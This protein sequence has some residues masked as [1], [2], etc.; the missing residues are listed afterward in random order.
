MQCTTIRCPYMSRA[1]AWSCRT[2]EL[3]DMVAAYR[4][5]Y[6]CCEA[7]VLR[8]MVRQRPFTIPQFGVTK[9]QE[10]IAGQAAGPAPRST[11][12]EFFSLP[13]PNR[14]NEPAC[15]RARFAVPAKRRC[16]QVSGSIPMSVSFVGGY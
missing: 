13:I 16:S 2:D 14:L 15:A 9:E 3:V 7:K 4:V 6:N 12:R 1:I 8:C 10:F 5:K 11:A